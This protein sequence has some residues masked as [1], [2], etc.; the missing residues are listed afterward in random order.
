MKN[1]FK[2]GLLILICCIL[3]FRTLA[4]GILVSWSA[5]DVEG[6]TEQTFNAAKQLGVEDIIKKNLSVHSWPDAFLLM[7]AANQHKEDKRLLAGLTSQITDK[8]KSSLELTSKLII[9]ER[10]TSGEILFEGKGYRISDDIF[11]A[12]GR[13]NWILR[14]L[15][16]KN[17]GYIKPETSADELQKLQQKWT[18]WL[19]GDPVE[20]YRNMYESTEKGLEEIRSLEALEALIISLKPN[21]AKDKLTKDCLRR[22]YSTDK[23]P[24]DPSSPASLCNPDVYT[25]RYL[26]IVTGIKDKHDHTW[27]SKWLDTNKD[28]LEWNREKGMF[29][30]KK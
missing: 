22:L 2:I 27:W 26:T 8:A 12:A 25:H 16:K 7:V 24:D 10:I 18:R 1:R 11:A 15:T 23:L 28:R 29:E 9:W 5:R 4:D 20:E 21:N 19:K 30:V 17:F 3:E 6:V 13:S 14:N